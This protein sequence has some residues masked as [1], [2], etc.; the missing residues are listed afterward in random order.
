MIGYTGPAWE[1]LRQSPISWSLYSCS[2][3]QSNVLWS[4]RHCARRKKPQEQWFISLHI[5]SMWETICDAWACWS[6]WKFGSKSWEYRYSQNSRVPLPPNWNL[7]RSW[8]FEFWLGWEYP[9]PLPQKLKFSHFLA[10]WI[11]SVL[12]SYPPPPPFGFQTSE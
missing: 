7:G 5:R 8:H 3:T 11:F 9:F 4:D 6:G 10:L 12:I 2:F 1:T